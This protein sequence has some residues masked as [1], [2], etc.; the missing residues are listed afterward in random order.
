MNEALK[1]LEALLAN[2]NAQPPRFAPNSRYHGLPTLTHV[3]PNGRAVAYVAR[4][5]VPGPEAFA[6][7]REHLVV[8]GD[9]LDL[10]ASNYLGDA[11]LWWRI[12]DANVAMVPQSLT[13]APGQLL[14]I[15]QPGA[16][17]GGGG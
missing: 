14:R 13:E 3:L 12:A 1:Q 10:L 11:E 17:P 9:R 7:D 16:G 2:A 15:A 8:Q 5:F 6:G 4:R